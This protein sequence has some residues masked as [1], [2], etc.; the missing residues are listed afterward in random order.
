MTDTIFLPKNKMSL[1]EYLA[2]Q[3]GEDKKYE[4]VDGEVRIFHEPG[5]SEDHS[6]ISAHLIW[7]L[8]SHKKSTKKSLHVF[9][10][11]LNLY[12]EKLNRT[13]F[14]D[15]MVVLGEKE[16]FQNNKNLLTNPILIFEVLSD[17]TR[18]YDLN[19]KFEKYK[20]IPSF[21]EYV[22]VNQKK[23][24]VEVKSLQKNGIWEAKTYTNIEERAIL[25]SI[26]F[27]MPLRDIYEG[28]L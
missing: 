6:E 23:I 10:S 19:G 27:E 26:D 16:N 4:F 8:I 12:I 2:F 15:C 17:S 20:L 25:N 5:G 7:S 28:I 14:P 21:R 13:T 9:T 18:L 11:D 22:L 3:E 1:A 24:E